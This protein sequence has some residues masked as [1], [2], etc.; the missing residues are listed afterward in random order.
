MRLA[1]GPLLVQRVCA[2]YSAPVRRPSA[3][4]RGY[5]ADV[6]RMLLVERCRSACLR[7]FA[8]ATRF[9]AEPLLVSPTWCMAVRCTCC[10]ERK[11]AYERRR[12]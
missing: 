8:A 12:G 6:T 7:H 11:A 5:H 3:A 2:I 1:L 4:P 10:A 9:K